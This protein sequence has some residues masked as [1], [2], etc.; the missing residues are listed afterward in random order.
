MIL[1][2]DGDREPQTIYLKKLD[3]KNVMPPWAK[4]IC[5][6]LQSVDWKIGLMSDLMSR[7]WEIKDVHNFQPAAPMIDVDD[8][9]SHVNANLFSWIS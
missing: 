1:Y 7:S 9:G 4:W 2:G 5:F 3:Y 6:I 8:N